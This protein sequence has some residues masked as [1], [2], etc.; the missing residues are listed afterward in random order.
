M[1][2]VWESSRIEAKSVHQYLRFAYIHGGEARDIICGIVRLTLRALESGMSASDPPDVK[3]RKLRAAVLRWHPDKWSPAVSQFPPAEQPV[4]LSRVK[5]VTQRILE[6]K[7]Q[8]CR[9][10]F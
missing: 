5:D 9:D 6:E 7:R 4:L 2:Q 8:F 1:F 10:V 3:K